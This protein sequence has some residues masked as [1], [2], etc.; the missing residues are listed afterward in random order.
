MRSWLWEDCRWIY[1]VGAN[2]GMPGGG[3]LP[4]APVLAPGSALGSRP[5][6]AL[7]SAQAPPVYRGPRPPGNPGLGQP[8]A[9]RGGRIRLGLRVRIGRRFKDPHGEGDCRRGAGF[10]A[11]CCFFSI[12]SYVYYEE[13]YSRRDRGH[14]RPPICPATFLKSCLRALQGA[15]NEVPRGTDRGDRSNL[16]YGQF[17][18]R[19]SG[20][21]RSRRQA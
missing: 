10:G 17:G 4:P 2:P 12:Y 21:I 1:R 14:P 11:L 15:P 6:V 9:R 8:L 5:R 13:V 18:G 20:T 7:S 19:A 16:R 3:I